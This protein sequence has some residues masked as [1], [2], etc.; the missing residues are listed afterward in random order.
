MPEQGECGSARRDDVEAAI[1]FAVDVQA[2]FLG[3]FSNHTDKR[4]EFQTSILQALALMNGKFVSDATS[5]EKSV[6][7]AGVV[8]APWMKTS[9]KVEALYLAALSRKPRAE[10]LERL[11]TAIQASRS[12]A[13][14]R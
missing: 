2:E 1:V 7:L 6:T 14:P 4:T 13:Q 12:S 11:A 9:D 5:V 8:D 3:R 10:E